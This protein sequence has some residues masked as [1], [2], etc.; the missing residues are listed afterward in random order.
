MGENGA[1]GCRRPFDEPA[2]GRLP[3]E[4]RG[5][6]IVEH[7]DIQHPVPVDVHKR[8]I[9]TVV[10]IALPGLAQQGAEPSAGIVAKEVVQ[11]T[12]LGVAKRIG[13]FETDPARGSFKAW[14]L[15]QT[16][17]RIAD[18]FRRRYQAAQTAGRCR[19]TSSEPLSEA[20]GR[21]TVDRIPDPAGPG[22]D[23][24][25]DEEWAEHVRRTALE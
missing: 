21:A 18:Q 5:L 7:Q 25:W 23:R 16:R 11:E 3:V 1:R 2:V 19:P 4:A 20:T 12:V 24:A 14:L 17:W 13:E 9:V 22:L 8:T 15:Q 10:L 6:I